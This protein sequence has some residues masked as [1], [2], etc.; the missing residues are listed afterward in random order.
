[1]LVW[2]PRRYAEFAAERARPFLDLLGR[3]A[4][5]APRTV[6]DLGCGSGELTASLTRRWPDA[7]L[8]GFDS[9]PEMVERAQTHA[10]PRLHFAVGD[11]TAW[12]PSRPVD[13]VVS[14]A[15]LQWVP[16]HRAVLPGLVDALAR[17]GW[18]AFQVPG[19]FDSPSHVLLHALAGQEPYRSHTTGLT[20]AAAAD[21]AD[22]LADLMVLDCEV[23]AWESTYV[24]VLAGPEAVWRWMAG[25]GARP[26]LQA[27][28]DSLR[29]DFEQAYRAEL[30]G[31]YPEQPWG[32][33]LPFR[34]VFVVARRTAVAR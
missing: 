4:A 25:T 20:R 15:A 31:A 10:G 26:V 1:M 3:V 30:A 12:A 7:D 17:N 13:V 6:V 19:N 18:L 8:L 33:V 34:R 28:P 22:Y 27:L 9:S 2:D 16:Q 23:D 14:N 32:T 29:T 11:L 5:E 21:P 24:H